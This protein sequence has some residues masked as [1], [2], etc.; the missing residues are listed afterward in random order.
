M[1]TAKINK[2]RFDNKKEIFNAIVGDSQTRSQS[3]LHAITDALCEMM[4]IAD[5]QG[6]FVSDIIEKAINN[7]RISDKQAWCVAFFAEKN[8]FV[9]A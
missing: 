7:S 6:N 9:K 8:G 3:Y 2:G 1:N 5:K 4:E